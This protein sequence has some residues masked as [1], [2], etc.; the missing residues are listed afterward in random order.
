M[1]CDPYPLPRRPPVPISCAQFPYIC[2]NL[3]PVPVSTPPPPTGQYPPPP[4]PYRPHHPH[5]SAPVNGVAISA[6]VLGALCF[7]PALGLVLGV[8]A[9]LQIRRSKE[10]GKGMAIA[11]AALSSAGLA[12]WLLVLSTDVAARAWDGVKEAAAGVGTVT[13]LDAGECFDLP[14]G[15][16]GDGEVYDVDEVPCEQPHDGEVFA[17][18]ALGGD[19]YPGSAGLDADTKCLARKAGYAMDAWAVPEEADVYSLTPTE[20]SWK[21]GDREITCVFANE[22]EGATLT[23]SLRRDASNL[24]GDQLAFLKAMAA[25]DG[26]LADEPYD[27]AED[28][29]AANTAWASG[30]RDALSDQIA[31]LKTHPW[32]D[33]ARPSVD[34][35]V[36]D[37]TNAEKDWSR[38]AAAT[39]PDDFYGYYDSGYEYVD[40]D[41]TVDARKALDLATTPPAYDDQGDGGSDGSGG[42]DSGSDD[43]G[44]L[45]V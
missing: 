45:D 22:S 17:V 10:R 24:N 26:A 11:G 23:G 4:Y 36:E 1:E 8:I 41:T 19:T 40:G 35:L 18:I 44:G 2:P 31:A 7:V 38:A 16:M 29:L 20:D 14:Y 25:V 39:D 30:V 27:Y 34:A 28:D 3:E 42:S 33:V 37:M 6:L 5:P 13:A 32:S 12:L 43:A 9:L 15:T 21:Y